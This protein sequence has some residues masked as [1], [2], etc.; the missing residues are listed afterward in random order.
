MVIDDVVTPAEKKP[1]DF[2]SLGGN[3][4]VVMPEVFKEFVC[5]HKLYPMESGC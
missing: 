4:N 5:V 1:T 2:F 3:V